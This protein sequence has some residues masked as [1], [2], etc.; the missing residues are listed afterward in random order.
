VR[1][2]GEQNLC[3]FPPDPARGENFPPHCSQ[4]LLFLAGSA[5]RKSVGWTFIGR[6]TASE[7]RFANDGSG[8]TAELVFARTLASSVFTAAP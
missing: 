6:K 1:H 8:V 7:T 3:G 5:D 4:V 2:C